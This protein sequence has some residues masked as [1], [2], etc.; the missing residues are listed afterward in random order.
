MTTHIRPSLDD[1]TPLFRARWQVSTGEAGVGST[2]GQHP[3][4][5]RKNLFYAAPADN[6]NPAHDVEQ[7][8][9]RIDSGLGF[10]PHHHGDK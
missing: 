4:W 9:E 6:H 8:L 10:P 1:A 3:P 7:Q 5:S 2:A